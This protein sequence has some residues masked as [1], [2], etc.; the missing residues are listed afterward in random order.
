MIY[1]NSTD[2]LSRDPVRFVLLNDPMPCVL[3][4]A[5]VV[6]HSPRRSCNILSWP[7]W[8]NAGAS[9]PYPDP[10]LAQTG[11]ISQP[12]NHITMVMGWK[13]CGDGRGLA[14]CCQEDAVC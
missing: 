7:S 14:Q 6:L 8:T 9:Q 5:S 2:S 3:L 1:H 13:H 11:S 10:P 12:A 4:S